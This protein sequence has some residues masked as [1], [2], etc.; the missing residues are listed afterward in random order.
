M[1]GTRITLVRILGF[2]IRA[3]VSW[4]FLALLITWSL[5]EGFFPFVYEGLTAATYWAM[6]VAGAAGLFVS[7]LFHEMAHSLVARRYGLPIGGITLFLFGGVA[8]MEEEPGDARTEFLM[9]IAGPIASVVLGAAF[10][11]VALVAEAGGVP[12]HIAGVPRYL[13]LVNGLLA[14]FNMLPAFPLDGGRAFRA[15]VWRWRGDLVSATRL[16]TRIG[17]GFGFLLIALGV[18]QAINGNFVGGMWW[19]LIGLFLR[20]N[21]SAAFRRLRD[22]QALEGRTARSFMTADPVTVPP[23]ITLT[24]LV[25][26]YLYRYHHELFP[27]VQ[28][29][30]LLGCIGTRQVREVPPERRDYSRVRDVMAGCG[31]D[32][33]VAAETPAETVLE[34]MQRGGSARLM[35][36]EGSRLVGVVTLRDLLDY[37]SVRSQL[38]K[39]G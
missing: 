15:L 16:A 3:D 20:G 32:T 31:D 19:F 6:A 33:T 11:A 4:V 26:D 21:A 37:L 23:D 12:D 27:V 38:E 29:S 36:T 14:A 28:D 24:E 18:L 8:E 10:F 39:A 13:G 7:L 5:A 9:A 2:D 34:R 17:E 1:F 22:R 25:E 30:R 35:V